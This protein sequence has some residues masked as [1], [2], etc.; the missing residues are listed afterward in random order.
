LDFVAGLFQPLGNS[1]F[2][3]GLAHL[4][5]DDVSWHDFLPINAPTRTV[6]GTNGYY[7]VWE[8]LGLKPEARWAANA[9][10]KRRSSTLRRQQ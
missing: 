3:D 2:D 1:A 4:G 9:A 7:S 5:H 6:L 8:R 10:L